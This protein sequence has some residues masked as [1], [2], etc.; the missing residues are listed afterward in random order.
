MIRENLMKINC[1]VS[2]ITAGL[3]DTRYICFQNY[4]KSNNNT[5]KIKKNNLYYYFFT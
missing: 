2:L 1:D 4:I 5:F 3:H